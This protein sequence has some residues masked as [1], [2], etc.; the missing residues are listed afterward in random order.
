MK[1]DAI[2][3]Q[4]AT[5]WTRGAFYTVILWWCKT[6]VEDYK[7]LKLKNEQIDKSDTNCKPVIRGIQ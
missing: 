2:F 1:K 5:E 7:T 3:F 6:Y 4:F